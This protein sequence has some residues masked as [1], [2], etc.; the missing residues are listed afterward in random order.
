ME[1]ADRRVGLLDVGQAGVVRL[2]V[3]LV[4]QQHREGLLDPALQHA[5]R[6]AEA[7]VDLGVLDVLDRQAE[8]AAVPVRRADL[9][10]EVADDEEDAPDAERIAQQLEV[11][12]EQRLARHLEQHLREASAAWVDTLALASRGDDTDARRLHPSRA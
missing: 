11:P 9:L 10:A 12:R 3:E 7:A 1:G 8:A 2:E 5:Q 6:G 4:A